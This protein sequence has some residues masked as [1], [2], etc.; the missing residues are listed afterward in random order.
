MDHTDIALKKYL[1]SWAERQPLP[2]G[3]RTK[4]MLATASLKDKQGKDAAKNFAETPYDLISWAMVSCLEKRFTM[5]R[6]VS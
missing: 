3:G 6:L 4:L 2:A 5:A 1:K